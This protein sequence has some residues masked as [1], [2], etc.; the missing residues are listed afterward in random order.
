MINMRLQKDT[1][2][3]Q[4]I[5]D[6]YKIKKNSDSIILIQQKDNKE[7]KFYEEIYFTGIIT[8]ILM[9]FITTII[10]KFI[11]RKKNREELKKIEEERKKTN[12]EIKKIEP[13]IEKL[14]AERKKYRKR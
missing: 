11:Y 1:I 2:K 7:K 3:V 4:L 9:A 6:G 14:N 10:I 5:S 12:K 8:P 13:E